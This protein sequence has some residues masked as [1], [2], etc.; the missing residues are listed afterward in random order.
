MVWKYLLLTAM[1]E[2]TIQ[3]IN[4]LY[5]TPDDTVKGTFSRN[6]LSNA[7]EEIVAF[8]LKYEPLTC[9]KIFR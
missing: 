4:T 7:Y 8:G 1:F 6:S 5:S 3:G 9:L 2:R